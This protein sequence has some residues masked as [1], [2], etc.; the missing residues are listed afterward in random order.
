MGEEVIVLA[1]VPASVRL[2]PGAE[3][4][5]QAARPDQRSLQQLRP[6]EENAGGAQRRVIPD[7]AIG[8]AFVER[9]HEFG[10]G[11]KDRLTN[12]ASQARRSAILQEP[13]RDGQL[14]RPDGFE[15]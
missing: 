4:A 11:S 14:E 9:R 7:L 2:K 15:I 6:V 13:G 3:K 10:R 5:L 8:H 12:S 1:L